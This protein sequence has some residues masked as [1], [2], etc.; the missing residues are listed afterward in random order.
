[1][2][3]FPRMTT[4]NYSNSDDI[5]L[6][7][8]SMV[9]LSS[10]C[11]SDPQPSLVMCLTLGSTNAK[12]KM[13]SRLMNTCN[14]CYFLVRW[15]QCMGVPNFCAMCIHLVLL[16][17]DL[18]RNRGVLWFTADIATYRGTAAA[19]DASN[20]G[21]A[22]LRRLGWNPCRGLG[23]RYTWGASVVVVLCL[24][25]ASHDRGSAFGFLL[26]LLL[27]L[28]FSFFPFLSVN[29]AWWFP[30]QSILW[31]RALVSDTNPYFQ[32]KQRKP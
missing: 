24:W 30:F 20:K 22:M 23:K 17:H 28:V 14:R 31:S 16:A 18:Y 15:F 26:L 13:P 29:L 19:L 11:C 2:S 5:F 21:H 7:S 3:V 12:L 8:W 4:I 1:M 32:R 10:V 27:L 25:H 6:C 9:P